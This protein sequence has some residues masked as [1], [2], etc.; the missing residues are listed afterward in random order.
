MCY[1]LY[2]DAQRTAPVPCDLAVGDRVT[3]TNDY[4]VEF[5]NRVVTGFSP[6]VDFGR[7]VYL[8]DEA[9]WFAVKPASLTKQHA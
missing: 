8:D 2:A 9:W 4:G 6:S 5:L 7:F 1:P 3:Y